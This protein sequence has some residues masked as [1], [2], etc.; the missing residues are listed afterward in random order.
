MHLICGLLFYS[1]SLTSTSLFGCCRGWLLLVAHSLAASLF[2]SAC[3]PSCLPFENSV[4]SGWCW[5]Q[6]L[7]C[8]FCLNFGYSSKC[9]G[10]I[11]LDLGF[12]DWAV[13]LHF[14]LILCNSCWQWVPYIPW[15][16]P[17][18]ANSAS[19][20]AQKKAFSAI[21]HSIC[22]HS[23]LRW[24]SSQKWNRSSGLI[25]SMIGFLIP[26]L[27]EFDFG[28]GLFGECSYFALFW[29]V[30]V[31]PLYHLMTES[32]GQV[33]HR[34]NSSCWL[35]CLTPLHCFWSSRHSLDWAHRLQA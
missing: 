17:K 11:S 14:L 7:F 25:S 29:G 5:N 31:L 19:I 26:E 2:I 23:Q 9:H 24:D 15:V 12:C 8:F 18:H 3:S 30:W 33:N 22:F 1:S 6:S 13:P 27:T 4:L 32:P 20:L 28:F 16:M 34:C 35:I 21:S 10:Q